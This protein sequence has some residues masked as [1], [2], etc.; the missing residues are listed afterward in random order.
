MNKDGGDAEMGRRGDSVN[1]TPIKI[2]IHSP[3][4]H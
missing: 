3:T 1:L 2:L 4:N